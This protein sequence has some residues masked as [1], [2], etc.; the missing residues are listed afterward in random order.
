MSVKQALLFISLFFC[1]IGYAKD[2]D[3]TNFGAIADGKTVNTLAIQK[4]IDEC[5]RQGGGLVRF[6]KGTWVTGTIL[7][8]DNVRL[9]LEEEAILSGSLDINDY[10]LVEG[11]RDGRGSSMGYALIGAKDAKNTGITGKGKING[12]GKPLLEKNGRSKRPFLVRFIRCS[13]VLV[14]EVSM[15]GPA[16][17][18]MHF[19]ECNKVTA[20]KVVIRSRGL[21]N[22]DGID[23]DC[24]NSVI[25]KDCDIDSGDDAI[26][27]KTTGPLP[28][29]DIEVFNCKINT[30]QGAFKLGTESMGNF[31]NI[32]F[33]DCA[34]Q[35]TRGIKIFSVDGS[36]LRNLRISNIAIENATL[37][38]LIRLGAR[39]KTFREG[40]VKKP[41]GSIQGVVIKNVMVKNATQMAI[42]ISGIPDQRIK[43]VSISG[44]KVSLPGGGTAEDAKMILP[45]NEADYPEITMFGKVMPAY[46]MFI[47]HAEQIKI[48]DVEIKLDK[49]DERPSISSMDL[50]GLTLGRCNLPTT[51]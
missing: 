5:S 48:K 26:C 39:L 1:T 42:L 13:N 12:N 46:G 24:C 43:N 31:E 41:V 27:L 14:S 18:T 15:E 19:F 33:H 45:E 11:F 51:K 44:I 50:K 36:H 9:F 6:P 28:C 25:V 3:V 20:D 7:L 30:G 22:N 35:N 34:V 4:T 8:K 38:L 21:G 2:F 23:I 49:A 16:A 37:P 10:Q 40:D 29:K 32:K 47:R 17:W